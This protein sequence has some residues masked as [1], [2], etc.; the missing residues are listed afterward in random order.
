VA[1]SAEFAPS[2]AADPAAFRSIVKRSKRHD[3]RQ[4]SMF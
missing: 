4:L 1:P 3:A 2:F